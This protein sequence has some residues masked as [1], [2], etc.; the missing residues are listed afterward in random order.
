MVTVQTKPEAPSKTFI[1]CSRCKTR[2]RRCDGN[3]PK[4]SNC[5]VQKDNGNLDLP[6]ATDFTARPEDEEQPQSVSL[7]AFAVNIGDSE[8]SSSLNFPPSKE[9]LPI[10]PDF[11]L[12]GTFDR[13]LAAFKA[14]LKEATAQRTF[15]PLIPLH[16]SRRLIDNSFADVMVEHP[17]ISLAC[18][19]TLLEAQYA[20]STVGP[21]EDASRWALVNAVLA[22]AIRF[23]TAV[24]SE[25]DISPVTESF[26]Q[27]SVMVV[28][29]LILQDPNLVSVQA[30]LAMAVFSRGLPDPQAFILLTT[31]ASRHLEILSRCRFVGN[32]TSPVIYD[33]DQ[34][35]QVYEVS[36]R[37]SEEASLIMQRQMY[38]PTSTG[39]L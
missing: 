24:G 25:S 36:N 37:L 8:S 31:N 6:N 35:E 19:M 17:F 29:Q 2:K 13:N 32:F 11:L 5:A 39:I 21:A 12:P 3:T 4:C 38:E 1:A 22:L 16:I 26:Y 34:F 10:F 9:R 18:F 33:G 15:Y 27:N 30:L 23:K 7:G 14:Q 20:T 28:R